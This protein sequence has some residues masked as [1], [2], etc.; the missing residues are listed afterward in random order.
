M[1]KTL[2]FVSIFILVFFSS[3]TSVKAYEPL[4]YWY[5]DVYSISSFS[6]NNVTF[7]HV[8]YL[9]CGMSTSNYSTY[10]SHAMNDWDDT[11]DV[12]F[13]NVSSNGDVESACICRVGASMYEVD[14]KQMKLV[15]GLE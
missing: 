8:F 13:S 6:Q 10:L 2:F 4:P 9:G 15:Y 11:F 12:D 5:S 7:N 14:E 1:K 3:K